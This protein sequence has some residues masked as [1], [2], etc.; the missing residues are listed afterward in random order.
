MTIDILDELMNKMPLLWRYYWCESVACACLGC[1]NSSGGLTENG[2]NR[3]D[4]EQW[5]KEHPD[6][7]PKEERLP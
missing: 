5:V 4:W 6:S 3:K 7:R 1:A 2:F